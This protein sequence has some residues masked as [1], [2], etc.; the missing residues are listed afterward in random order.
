[1]DI[2]KDFSHLNFERRIPRLHP[3]LTALL[4]AVGI[5]LLLLWILPMPA[6]LV[7][8]FL[9]VPILVWVASYGWHNAL[10]QIIRYLERLQMY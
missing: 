3:R 7:I 6:V 5:I 8:L 1:M 9:I 4:I 2:K 10:E